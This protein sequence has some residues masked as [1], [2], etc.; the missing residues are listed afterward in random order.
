MERCTLKRQLS[1]P[2]LE[3]AEALRSSL[4]LQ[5]KGGSPLLML[6][7]EKDGCR[8]YNPGDDTV[9]ETKSD[10]SGYRFVASSG[11]WFLVIDSRMKL[12]IIDVFGE[13][14]RIDLPGLETFKG[15]HFKIER[16]GEDKIRHVAFRTLSRTDPSTAEDVR[17]R[18]WVEDKKGGDFVVLWLFERSNYIAFC[19]KGDDHYREIS[20]RDGVLGEL[21]GVNDM[22]LKGYDLYIFATRGFV[23][24]LDLS[25]RHDGFIDVSEKHSFP[26]W[27]PPLS[28]DEMER[29]NKY[30]IISCIES[31]AVVTSSGQVLIVV[32][33]ELTS[34]DRVFH[35]YKRDPQVLYPTTY[36]TMFVEVHS[37]G[38]EALF[39]DLGITVPADHTLG[40]EPNSIYFTRGDRIRHRQ[41]SSLD[42]CV[43]SLTTKT[44][45]RYPCL[46]ASNIK[47]AQWFLPS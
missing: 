39:L 21:R 5:P 8:V 36:D 24:H 17:G 30:K 6:S 20:T 35:L 44:V 42:I 46:D 43:F 16:V 9:Y 4:I 45:K 13:E 32:T 25:P 34:K 2:D 33:Y 15:S 1:Y 7:Q 28:R 22:L 40:I 37:L 3:S 11:K 38:D 12:Y 19:K 29:I 41:T 26:R 47:D 31:I 27:L 10:L 14:E 23:R 18:L